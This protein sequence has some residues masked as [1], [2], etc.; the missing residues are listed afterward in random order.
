MTTRIKF[1]RD[2]AAN[3]TAED[4]VLALGEPGF[5]QDTN[6]LKIGDGETAWS[7]LDYASG[8][9]DSLTSDHNIAITVGNTDYWA[10]VHR[11]NT[12]NGDG[13]GGVEASGVAYDSDNNM[14]VLHVNSLYNT[15]TDTFSNQLI[16]S[17]YSNTG[18]VLWQKQL[19]DDDVD[20]DQEHSVAVD[21]DDNIIVQTTLDNG[22]DPDSIV[23]L[24]IDGT[25]GSILW[26]K[27]Y[28]TVAGSRFETGGMVLSG[29]SIFV[30]ATYTADTEVDPP[31]Y[32][33]FVMKVSAANGN[34]SW[35]SRFDFDTTTEV[36]GMHV[37]TTGDPVVVGVYNNNIGVTTAFVTRFNGANGSA[38][39]TQTIADPDENIDYV[40]GDIV[41]DSQ[42][43]IFVSMN[44]E[45]NIVHDDDNN[46]TTTVAYVYKLNSAGAIQ[47]TRRIGPGP[48]A[49]VATG[50]DCDSSGNVYLAALTLTQDNPN[51][52]FGNY[53][54]SAR[55]VLA[56]AKYSTA[57]AV[58]WQRYIESSNREFHATRSEGNNN[59][60]DYNE[61]KNRGRNMSVNLDGK[62][63]VQVTARVLDMDGSW[64]NNRYWESI[65][66]QID[67][68]GREMT[69]GSGNEKFTVKE[70][71]IPGR[72]VT[73]T[74]TVIEDPATTLLEDFAANVTVTTS[75]LT[76]ANGE[77]AQ[78]VIK[79][80][81]YE[82]VFGNDGTLT[83]PN[84]GDVRLTQTQLGWF[85]IFGSP[86]NNL[87]DIRIICV[88]V[89]PATG[90][91]Y[92]AGEEN[93]DDESFVAR[94]NSEGQLLWSI[95]LQ[96]LGNSSNSFV[97]DLH[98]HPE[99][100]NLVALVEV[101]Y[102]AGTTQLIQID[103]DTAKIVVQT[104]FRDTENDGYTYPRG[105]AF[106]SNANVVVVGSKANEWA[107]VSVTAQAGSTVGNILVLASALPEEF[108]TGWSV[109]GTGI[110]IRATIDSI[111][112]YNNVT[113]TTR[114][115]SGATFDVTA[116]DGDP[117]VYTAT[118]NSGGTNYLAGHKI[119]ILG[120]SLGGATPAND[121]IL[122][123]SGTGGGAIVTLAAP[124]GTADGGAL[125]TYTGVSGTNHNVGSGFSLN[126]TFN[127]G[128][129][130]NGDTINFVSAIGGN[131][132]VASDVITVLG[133]VLGGTTPTNDMTI[134]VSSVGGSGDLIDWTY[135]GTKQ[136]TT[137]KIAIDQ[138]ANF[139]GAGSWVLQKP[140]GGE[141][142]VTVGSGENFAF[143]WT[144]TAGGGAENEDDYYYSVAV[145]SSDNIYACGQMYATANIAGADL[146]S[147][148]CSVVSKYNSTGTHQWTK[149]L[150][151]S[152]H[153]CYGQSVSVNG[154]H[155]AA[156]HRN[157]NSG[158]SVVTKLDLAGN[159]LWQRSTAGVYDGC[160]V[161][162]S[163]GDIY[164]ALEASMESQYANCIKVI[165]FNTHGEIV[166][167][168]I[169]ATG[170]YST[171]NDF[172]SEY[173]RTGR[174][175]AIDGDHV[176]VSG[177]TTA[178]NG[179]GDNNA[180]VVK[181]PK[182]GD[183]DGLYGIWTIMDD[184][185]DVDKV[186]Q[187]QVT[188]MTPASGTGA[189]TVDALEL[190]SQWWDPSDGDAEYGTT[191]EIRDRDGGA[192]EFADG[193]RQTSS[194]QQIS[195]VLLTGSASHRLTLEDMGK[196]IYVKDG[197]S[198]IGVPYHQD[199]ALPIGFTV[200]IVNNSG[201]AVN[202]DADGSSIDIVVPGVS[203]AQYWDLANPGMATLIKVEQNLWFMTGDVSVD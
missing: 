179:D 42:N 56:I 112:A 19:S 109:A 74:S 123:V 54:N 71:R 156:I 40:N 36:Y 6:K 125:T 58:I 23:L 202:I 78:L 12:D 160:L 75:A 161:T 99:T 157:D 174:N 192:I 64:E 28:A 31:P 193:T 88:C 73:R 203:T 96:E 165:R 16:I 104:G 167:R 37:T 130:Y 103:P 15:V 115:G 45:E 171:V 17:K 87:D 149:V 116:N 196:H 142:F 102:N 137:R 14:I 24:K 162:D 121:L 84:D 2:T 1:R 29:S 153:D 63:A 52:E 26:Q 138:A 176:Y 152:L 82:Y 97:R 38:T 194:A 13:D 140:I 44:S 189:F 68:D 168:K 134:T 170:V 159:V 135:S 172:T 55:N 70:S 190:E 195:Q 34:L 105:V 128:A 51:R 11:T 21:T 186:L 197:L 143:N 10:I 89:D 200:V 166:W 175:I 107:N 53:M 147:Y 145:D 124:E 146:N 62:L 151:D 169:L 9:S 80:A 95:I 198:T 7:G 129:A 181:L 182:T 126:L 164:A 118:I 8:G 79:S 69:V 119:K 93:D 43:N 47:W 191:T 67:Q 98:M 35:A 46:L 18:T 50:I 72:L 154:T 187:T 199:I 5:E 117:G 131:N 27:D 25:D 85:A 111:D 188:T 127:N 65:T 57:G 148:W 141:A 41:L 20:S 132:Y 173:M 110:N 61:R 81:P 100:G 32:Y 91:V 86:E 4:P 184:A 178:P 83:I 92:I 113:G 33:G 49:S 94:Y 150:N 90:D 163:N 114:E 120:T 22:D 76:T 77:L 183:C 177:E 185:Y 3:W 136:N 122:T 106:T 101:S 158:T 66:F 59:L 108:D 30:S 144:R 201:S 48:C 39:W 133:N 180:F 60:G 139:G 155:L